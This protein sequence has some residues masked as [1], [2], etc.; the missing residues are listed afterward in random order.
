MDTIA[1]QEHG[2][3]NT[4]AVSGTA[5]T[6]KQLQILKRLTRKIYLCFDGDKAGTD[7]TKLV[8][9]TMK[10]MVDCTYIN[11]VKLGKKLKVEGLDPG[12]VP[13]S[14]LKKMKKKYEEE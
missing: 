6:E 14:F 10:S 9:P 11:A 5:L 7:A 3:P 8:Y 1:L 2:F 13:K 4:V 12:N